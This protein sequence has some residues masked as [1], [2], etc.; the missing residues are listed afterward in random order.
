[1]TKPPR[2]PLDRHRSSYGIALR[3]APDGPGGERSDHPGG[4]R[5][6]LL[7]RLGGTLRPGGVTLA[8]PLC[9]LSRGEEARKRRRRHVPEVVG[10]L[11]RGA[12]RPLPDRLVLGGPGRQFPPGLVFRRARHDAAVHLV[13]RSLPQKHDQLRVRQLA[14]PYIDVA[15][16]QP[17]PGLVEPLVVAAQVLEARAPEKQAR[18]LVHRGE[19][20]VLTGASEA[21]DLEEPVAVLRPPDALQ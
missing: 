1:M 7:C 19:P 17:T 16:D 21:R 4:L 11:R 15:V 14:R 18:T 8:P 20:A 13:E 12:G 3:F 10:H 2:T 9:G 6:L 5:H